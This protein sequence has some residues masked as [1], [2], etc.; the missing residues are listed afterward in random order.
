MNLATLLST[1]LEGDCELNVVTFSFPTF[2]VE[3]YSQK[4]TNVWVM[5]VI[6]NFKE[7]DERAVF[8]K[9]TFTATNFK[10]F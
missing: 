1:L 6:Y 10:D 2:L 5:T 8:L 9:E 7:A 3:E 4:N